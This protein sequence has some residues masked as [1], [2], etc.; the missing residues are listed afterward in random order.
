MAQNAFLEKLAQEKP[1]LAVK[2]MAHLATQI[3][4]DMRESA[5]SQAIFGRIDGDYSAVE[6][7]CDRELALRERFMDIARPFISEYAVVGTYGDAGQAR[8]IFDIL[9]KEPL[10]REYLLTTRDGS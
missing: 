1:R 2:Y 7:A 4:G 8:D 10:N 5:K 9:H 6:R 3:Q